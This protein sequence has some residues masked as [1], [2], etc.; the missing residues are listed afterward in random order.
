M[1]IELGYS[2]RRIARTLK[3]NVSTITRE[4]S[5]NQ[6]PSNYQLPSKSALNM[7]DALV[8]SLQDLPQA[9]RKSIPYDNG[10]ENVRH[11]AINQALGTA[12]FFCQ[13][14]SRWEKGSV[15][16]VIGLIRRTYPKKT[17]WNL[18]SQ[19]DFDTIQFRLNNRPKKCLNFLSPAEAYA[20][21]LAA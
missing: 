3:R 16:N 10:T 12:S 6:P 18:I 17:D 15:E 21:A 2:K 19:S 20:V 5:R 13:P 9:L 4:C 1:S 8:L 11:G 7:Q 14:Y